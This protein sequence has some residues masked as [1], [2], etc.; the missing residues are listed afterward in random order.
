V[1]IAALLFAAPASTAERAVRIT[2]LGDSLVAGLRISQEDAFP[3]K[4]ERVLRAKGI[5]VEVINAGVS[6]DTTSAGLAR[7]DRSV[8]KGTDAVIVELGTNDVW[9]GLAPSV[10][11]GAIQ[12]IVQRLRRR[13]IDVLL[14]GAWPTRLADSLYY[15]EVS[16][17]FADLA[18]KSGLIF[19]PYFLEGVEGNPKLTLDGLHPNPLAWMKLW[20]AYFR[21]WRNLSR[22]FSRGPLLP[23]H[24]NVRFHVA[25][26]PRCRGSTPS[27][28]HKG[29]SGT[30]KT[31]C[32]P[33]RLSSA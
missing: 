17:M 19:Y 1:I 11:R 4:L 26:C 6:G 23:G 16:A 3:A 9:R 32:A 28:H 5:S 27:A 8:P 14:C 18:K 30:P 22:G 2:V 33:L 7:L 10:T 24:S 31:W 20:L 21:A 29:F 13:D 25:V 15:G 12:E